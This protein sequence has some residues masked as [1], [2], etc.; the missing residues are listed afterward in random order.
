MSRGYH[1]RWDVPDERRADPAYIEAGDA[2]EFGQAVFDRRTALGIS[3]TELARRAQMT[4]PQASRL[5]G[6]GT[7]PTIALLHRLAAALDATLAISLTGEGT[8][9]VFTPNAA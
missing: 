1:T 4:Q 6:G 3:Q 9:V 7:V 5:E 2:I 8:S